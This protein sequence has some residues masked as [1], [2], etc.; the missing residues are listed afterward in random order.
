MA[1]LLFVIQKSIFNFYI[2]KFLINR[3]R[4]YVF[5]CLTFLVSSFRRMEM[6][7]FF[8]QSHLIAR[9]TAT[10]ITVPKAMYLRLQIQRMGI[11]SLSRWVISS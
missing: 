5:L 2:F 8:G 4:F 9:I 6:V 10:L 1:T 7:H 11:K 3:S